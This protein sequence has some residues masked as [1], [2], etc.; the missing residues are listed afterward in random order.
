VALPADRRAVELPEVSAV[1][2]VVEL[3]E[4]SAVRP[5]VELPEVSAVRPV[6]ELPEVSA[7][8][9]VAEL[10]EVSAV[11]PVAELLEV[12]A[13]RPVALLVV[14]LAVLNLDIPSRRSLN[15]WHAVRQVEQMSKP[16]VSGPR[17]ARQIR[18]TALTM[19]PGIPDAGGCSSEI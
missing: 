1:H 13:V 15:H 17:V 8:R 3:P 6:A 9:P 5:V 19:L 14:R 12:S 18:G 7:V 11:R 4:V 2:P 16:Q 10:P